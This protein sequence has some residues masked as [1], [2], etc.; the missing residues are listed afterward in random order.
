MVKI[1]QM[2]TKERAVNPGECDDVVKESYDGAGEKDWD[3]FLGATM[4]ECNVINREKV[5]QRT[6]VSR[7]RRSMH[8]Y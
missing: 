4:N 1:I 6:E 7:R 8:D 3:M 5:E 2:R